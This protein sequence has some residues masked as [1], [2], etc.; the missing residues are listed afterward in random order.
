MASCVVEVLTSI[1]VQL[2]WKAPCVVEPGKD[3]KTEKLG[4]RQLAEMIPIN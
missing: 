2:M 4:S 1:E 3:P